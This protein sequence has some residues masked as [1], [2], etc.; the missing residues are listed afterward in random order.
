M[1]IIVLLL[2]TENKTDLVFRPYFSGNMLNRLIE[3][4][5]IIAIDYQMRITT[6]SIIYED[7]SE[8]S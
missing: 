2:P 6:I 8:I 4:A 1:S 5:H 3:Y 7:N